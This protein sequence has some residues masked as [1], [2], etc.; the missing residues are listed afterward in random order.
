MRLVTENF[1][2]QP[3]N[4]LALAV[5]QNFVMLRIQSTVQ[6]FQSDRP[7]QL[8]PP[9]RAR[10]SGRR[11]HARKAENDPLLAIPTSPQAPVLRSGFIRLEDFR[12]LADVRNS[13]RQTVR[14]G[15]AAWKI[16]SHA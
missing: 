7:P 9:D 3:P 4:R 12:A 13:S 16:A 1:A 10:S 15:E 11:R 2:T 14:F 6:R 8:W 5:L